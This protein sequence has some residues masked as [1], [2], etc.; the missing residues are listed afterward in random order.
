VFSEH[1]ISD[2]AYFLL[3][4]FIM[5]YDTC[6]SKNIY[7]KA[8]LSNFKN[9][10][11]KLI[12]LNKEKNSKITKKNEEMKIPDEFLDS[13]SFLV[14]RNPVKLHTIGKV[15]DRETYEMLMLGNCLDSFNRELLSS[16]KI[17][18]DLDLK[19]ILYDR[20]K[21]HNQFRES[22]NIKF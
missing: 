22:T 15:V 14:M 8:K 4:L 5:C 20:Y 2:Q 11:N 17:S 19:K 12:I 3:N 1:I 18:V 9:F 10:I 13:V 21:K 6:K 16:E 7:S